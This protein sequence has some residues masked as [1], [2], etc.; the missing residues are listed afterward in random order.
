MAYG[1]SHFAV[2]AVLVGDGISHF[3]NRLVGG[4]KQNSVLKKVAARF[5]ASS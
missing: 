5:D 3:S 4:V 2:C 1:G